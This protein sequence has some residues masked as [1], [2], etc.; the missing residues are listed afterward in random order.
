MLG[1]IVAVVAGLLTPRAEAPLARPLARAMEGRIPVAPGE[2]RILA[3]ILMMLL[4]GVVA[5]L[6]H[7]GSAFWIILGGGLGYFGERILAAVRAAIDG[8]PR[9]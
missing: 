6:L 4:A 1:F 3:F 9:G 2:M 8:R 7:S 5:E